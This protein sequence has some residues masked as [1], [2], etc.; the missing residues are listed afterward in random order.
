MG[1][2]TYCHAN[3]YMRDWR[4]ATIRDVDVTYDPQ[5]DAP[6]ER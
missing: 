1:P 5:C 3:F 4:D 2:F 6:G